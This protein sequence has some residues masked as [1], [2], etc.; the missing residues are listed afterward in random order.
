MRLGHLPFEESLQS[1]NHFTIK[2][3]RLQSDFK[4]RSRHISLIC[5]SGLSKFHS[6]SQHRF[7]RII[8][9]ISCA[10]CS[11]RRVNAAARYWKWH[12]GRTMSEKFLHKTMPILSEHERGW[13][14]VKKIV[15]RLRTW[16]WLSTV[17]GLNW[18]LWTI[19]KFE[20]LVHEPL[21]PILRSQ[22]CIL[23]FCAR[24]LNLANVFILRSGVK[25]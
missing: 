9:A 15:I 18:P 6:F 1:P 20:I 16:I 3:S 24:P 12:W 22:C 23:S 17:Y 19:I 10:V 21:S 7:L 11:H 4:K 8:T 14:K 25:C 5:V 2:C 13:L